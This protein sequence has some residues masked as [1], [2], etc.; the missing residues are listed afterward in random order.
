MKSGFERRLKHDEN[1]IKFRMEAKARRERNQVSD[2]GNDG[3]VQKWCT[4]K[5]GV[6]MY[7]GTSELLY[8]NQAFGGG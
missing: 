6:R 5:A 8:I 2:Q 4:K 1:E 7:Y 3:I